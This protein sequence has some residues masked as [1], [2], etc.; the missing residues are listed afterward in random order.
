MDHLKDG[1]RT[2]ILGGP[3]RSSAFPDVSTADEVVYACVLPERFGIC[4]VGL[5]GT[6][7]HVIH[8]DATS[9]D[10][11]PVWSPD[12]QF[13]AFVSDRDDDDD[14]DDEIFI[15]SRDGTLQQLTHNTTHDADPAWSPDATHLAFT[16][17]RDG[18]LA[19]W[20]MDTDGANPR[21][22]IDGAKPGWSPDGKTVTHHAD[23]FSP[24]CSSS[25]S[26][27]NSSTRRSCAP[28]SMVPPQ[29]AKAA[30]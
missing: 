5:D 20:V 16:S 11:Q 12:G 3:N 23:C 22:V 18:T 24:A 1:A 28:F 6:D 26:R 27:C 29:T 2:E 10:W 8:D 15:L 30:T 17:E 14:D 19:V 9:R 21:R 7:P 13:V 25:A 4:V